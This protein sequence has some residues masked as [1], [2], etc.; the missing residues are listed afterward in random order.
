VSSA[1][2]SYNRRLFLPLGDGH[3]SGGNPRS[4]GVFL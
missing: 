4:H 1:R 2:W 3:E